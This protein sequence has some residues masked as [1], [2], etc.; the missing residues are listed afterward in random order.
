VSYVAAE[1]LKQPADA[2]PAH[3]AARHLAGIVCAECH[4]GDLSG[5]G[6]DSGAPDLAVVKGYSVAELTRLLRT[7]TASGGRKL[8]LMTRV[9]IDR[10]HRLSDAEIGAIHAY[11][12]AR[13]DRSENGEPYRR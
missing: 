8:G 11:L 4:G 5:N 12:T 2:G 3:A 6:W 1:R 7:G 9:S 10:L 13:N